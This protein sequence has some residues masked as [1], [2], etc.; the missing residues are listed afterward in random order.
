MTIDQV[1]QKFIQDNF[2]LPFTV[3]SEDNKCFLSPEKTH[4]KQIAWFC[5][6]ILKKN[7]VFKMDLSK[8]FETSSQI[9]KINTKLE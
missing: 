3:F 2:F 6:N 8:F 7:H 4:K 9:Q 5:K 1:G